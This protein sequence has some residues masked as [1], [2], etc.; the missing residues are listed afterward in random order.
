MLTRQF[1]DLDN[2]NHRRKSRHTRHE[3]K[4]NGVRKEIRAIT[5]ASK[6]PER[7][8]LR[9]DDMTEITER[10]TKKKREREEEKAQK[11]QSC[12]AVRTNSRKKNASK[13]ERLE[14]RIRLIR[15]GNLKV[16]GRP[17]DDLSTAL[18]L[19]EKLGLT[20]R[21]LEAHSINSEWTPAKRDRSVRKKAQRRMHH[22]SVYRTLQG[23]LPSLGK[24]SR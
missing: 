24:R 22:R 21:I 1:P 9:P 6:K 15:R 20:Q 5:S 18:A 8:V 19:E 10:F 12:T 23:G 17:Y 2:W 4:G 7:G 13:N 11:R 3:P 16:D 14:K